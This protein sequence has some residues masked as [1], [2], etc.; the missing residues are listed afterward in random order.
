[1]S[2]IEMERDGNRERV[3]KDKIEGER[4]RERG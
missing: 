3:C 2:E 1:M 4:E